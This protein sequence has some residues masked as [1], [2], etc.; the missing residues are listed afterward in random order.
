MKEPALSTTG[1]VEIPTR[2]SVAEG[3]RVWAQT[4]DICQN[5]LL[6]V[7]S[8]ALAH[9]LEAVQ[10]KV[11]LD[12][13]C[14][15]GRWAADAAARGAK[16]LGVDLSFEMLTVARKKPLLEGCLL[17]ADGCR[18]PL[19]DQSFDVAM[20]SFSVGY[21]NHPDQLMRELCRVVR[22]GGTIL[23]SDLHPLAQRRG[24]RR[25]F[26]CG[27]RVLEIESH[28]YTTERLID[29]GRSGGL[30]L[31]EIL[32]PHIAEPERPIMRRAG[33]EHLFGEVSAIPAVLALE[34]ERP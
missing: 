1:Q 18:L 20:C 7:E 13:A 25:S 9:K 4:Y 33:K 21:V 12:V 3:Y 17:Q 31:K 34:W 32:E 8:R 23:L 27:T 10:S 16:V 6:A 22:I 30:R 29:A 2:V 19:A 28:A 14:G 11:F 5:P 26:R 24:W 15:T